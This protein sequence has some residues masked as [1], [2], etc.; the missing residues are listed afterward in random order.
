MVCSHPSGPPLPSLSLNAEKGL[1]LLR[2]LVREEHRVGGSLVPHGNRS[3]TQYEQD[4]VGRES[5]GNENSPL[6]P[7][8]FQRSLLHNT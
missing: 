8:A 1:I 7:F 6:S 4:C 3:H 2:G 5:L